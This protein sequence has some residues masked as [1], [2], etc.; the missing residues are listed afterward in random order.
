MNTLKVIMLIGMLSGLLVIIGYLLGR[1]KG[2]IIALIISAVMNVG[3][4]WYSDSI[5]LK[6]YKLL[7]Y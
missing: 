6:M 5:V 1:G 7:T 4:Y 3:S 2:I